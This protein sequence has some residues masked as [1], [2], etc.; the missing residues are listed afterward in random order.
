[1]PEF[2]PYPETGSSVQPLILAL[3][4]ASNRNQTIA[5]W[6]FAVGGVGA[7]VAFA[8][9]AFL[10]IS[11]TNVLEQHP[12]DL[13][14]GAFEI[15][16]S[17]ALAGTIAAI[18]VGSL[19]LGRAALD[20][21]TR[22]EK[23]LMAAQFMHYAFLEFRTEIATGA[24]QFSEIVASID[25]WSRMVESAYTKVKFGADSQPFDLDINNDRVALRVGQQLLKYDR[26]KASD[27][28]LP[29]SS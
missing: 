18:V 24:I 6:V 17:A 4:E 26:K 27:P 10:A 14:L 5:K 19:N 16:K 12:D 3:R 20:Q 9:L 25:A 28:N 11:T 13:L 7:V 2:P 22:Y 23:R 1:M 29:K 15:S 8:W 21:A